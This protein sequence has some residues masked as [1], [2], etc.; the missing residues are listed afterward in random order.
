MTIML[1]VDLP[2]ELI[3]A[4]ASEIQDAKSLKQFALTASAFLET[5]QRILFSSVKL[6]GF[7]FSK[8]QE[9]HDLFMA[10]PHIPGYITKFHLAFFLRVG[11]PDV[12]IL[13]NIL[14]RLLNVRTFTFEGAMGSSWVDVG[15]VA[16]AVVEFIQRPHVAQLHF[17]GL[18][19]GVPLD[20]LQLLLCSVRSL[21]FSA[22]GVL[23]GDGNDTITKV[24]PMPPILQKLVM[25][26][27]DDICGT[28][29]RPEFAASLANVRKFG[30]TMLRSYDNSFINMTAHNLEQILF[31]CYSPRDARILPLPPLEALHTINLRLRH[32]DSIEWLLASLST[33][34]GSCPPNL[35]E[36]SIAY[37][38][39]YDPST[40]F[41]SEAMGT[42]DRQL[43]V[44]PGV[45]RIVWLLDSPGSHGGDIE[46]YEMFLEVM[47]LGLPTLNAQGRLI[48]GCWRRGEWDL[49]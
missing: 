42:M 20:V 19:G 29:A 34:S 40:P 13:R 16:P 8:Y 3:A 47:K 30:R 39:S 33:I 26:Q 32:Y 37:P 17:V 10:S 41:P 21:S 5:C 11:F 14:S 2:Q 46:E 31:V 35:E 7:P 22:V 9:L 25:E 15:A 43:A 6:I 44:F 23:R 4:V 45:R 28:I 12:Q 24:P 1:L 48:V 36:I 18:S 38:V 27:S 49:R